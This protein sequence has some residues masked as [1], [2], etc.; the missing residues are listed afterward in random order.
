MT[1]TVTTGLRTAE[2]LK[3]SVTQ[4]VGTV[5][6]AVHDD[7]SR[8]APG[9][10]RHGISHAITFAGLPVTSVTSMCSADPAMRRRVKLPADRNGSLNTSNPGGMTLTRPPTRPRRRQKNR[11]F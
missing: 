2:H 4:P 1:L 11:L 8:G 6:A 9:A 10:A 3:S 5:S 7:Y